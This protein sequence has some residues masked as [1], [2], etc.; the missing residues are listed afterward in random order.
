MG[1]VDDGSGE[2]L[3]RIPSFMEKGRTMPPMMLSADVFLE[4]RAEP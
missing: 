2:T 1:G 3:G 4:D